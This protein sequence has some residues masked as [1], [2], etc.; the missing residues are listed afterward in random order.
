MSCLLFDFFFFL[1]LLQYVD[2]PN[3]NLLVFLFSGFIV[4]PKPSQLSQWNSSIA[5]IFLLLKNPATQ[6]LM[7]L[8]TLQ[9]LQVFL[10]FS[11]PPSPSF[12]NGF[13][14]VF[15]FITHSTQRRNGTGKGVVQLWT[16]VLLFSSFNTFQNSFFKSFFFVCLCVCVCVRVRACQISLGFSGINAWLCQMQTRQL[17]LET[18]GIV[19][20]IFIIIFFILMLSFN[21]TQGY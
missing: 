3:A 19:H 9:A 17:W 16:I 15:C 11:T 2:F 14:V 13:S 8:F 21:P 10:F 18:K 20:L 5:T 7:L 1:S 6:S 4:I 12:V